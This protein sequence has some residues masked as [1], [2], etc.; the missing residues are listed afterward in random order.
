VNRRTAIAAL[1][2]LALAACGRSAPRLRE[3]FSVVMHPISHARIGRVLQ[4]ALEAALPDRQV[5][6]ST[7]ERSREMVSAVQNGQIDAALTFADIAYL[8]YT[9]ELTGEAYDH[10]R[11]IATLNTSRLYI[12]VRQDSPL[13]AIADFGGR[14]IS[15]GLKGGSTEVAARSVL[16]G[17]A[18]EAVSSF[19]SFDEAVTRLQAG[20][21]DAIFALGSQPLEPL[22]RA[23]E[24]GGRL[25]SVP[26]QTVARL[27]SEYPFLRPSL[28]PAGTYGESPVVGVGVDRVLLCRDSV[29]DDV[30]RRVTKAFF[31]ALPRLSSAD[32]LLRDMNVETARATA[33]P[34]HGGAA[35]YY[36][37]QQ[38]M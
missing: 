24:H 23:L 27:Q 32:A 14:R 5:A 38:L 4:P 28:I 34:L 3:R 18:I 15:L 10:L 9:G 13:R 36:R 21:L 22:D 35:R 26:E 25:I 11:G 37:E 6:L 19:E 29:P 16:E 20:E 2:N 12:L 1:G 7:S 31:D 17:L 30:V 33:V 8:A